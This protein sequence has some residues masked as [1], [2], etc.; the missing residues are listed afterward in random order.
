[1]NEPEEG[2]AGTR[3][4]G[5]LDAPPAPPLPDGSALRVVTLGRDE[6][7]RR[8]GSP[9]TSRALAG[10]TPAH[11]THIVLALVAY[12]K[13][14]RLLEIGT[15]SGQMTANLTA[16]SPPDAAVHSM[17]IVAGSVSGAAEQ[18]YEVPPRAEFARHADHFGTA[19]KAL[20]ITADSRQFDF[21]RLVPLDFAFIDGGHDFETVRSDSIRTYESLRSGGCMAWHDFGSR[22]A[23]VQ[24]KEA[25]ESLGF[26]EPIYHV[27]GTEV[28]F[29]FKGEGVGA[30]AG[31]DLP[32]IA[33]VWDGDFTPAHSLAA[34][35]RS[36]AAELIARRQEVAL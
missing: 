26:P 19:H 8:F 11:D 5:P 2:S 14:R 33:V 35:N 36:I 20:L 16:W 12:L 30:S 3:T 9:D 22:V 28:A 21:S 31:P 15:A 4:R 1:M 6:F 34:V 13:P 25:I 10:F 29:L 24:V 17:G 23:W 18:G 27:A 32:R 7:A